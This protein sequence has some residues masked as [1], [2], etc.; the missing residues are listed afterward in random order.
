MYWLSGILIVLF[1]CTEVINDYCYLQVSYEP[2]SSTLRR[3]QEEVAAAVIQRTYRKHL[4]QRT[5]KL[6]SYKYR[7]KTEGQRDELP[8]ETEGLLYKR[9]SQLY[10]DGD[11]TRTAAESVDAVS[12]EDPTPPARVELLSEFILHA[13]PPLNTPDFLRDENLRESIV[14][15][16]TCFSLPA[17]WE[18]QQTKLLSDA[19]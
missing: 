3:K 19:L 10:G 7:E 9:I 11:E 18:K 2:I 12:G 1:N 14:W 16:L 8:P 4:L 17:L 13:A 15:C 5:V 6:A